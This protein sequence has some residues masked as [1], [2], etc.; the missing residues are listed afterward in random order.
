MRFAR[1]RAESAKHHVIAHP[2]LNEP[3]VKTGAREAGR[4]AAKSLDDGEASPR[5]TRVMPGRDQR[6]PAIRRLD[7]GCPR[8]VRE[9]VSSV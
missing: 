4:S 8:T 1:S 2:R 6:L 5:I 3:L 9:R 7:A